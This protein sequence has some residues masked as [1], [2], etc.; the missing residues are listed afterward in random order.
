MVAAKAG[1]DKRFAEFFVLAKIP[2]VRT[3]LPTDYPGEYERVGG[4]RVADFQAHWADWMIA[5]A[6]AASRG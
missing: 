2:G 5:P 6:R 3:D 1:P 4:R